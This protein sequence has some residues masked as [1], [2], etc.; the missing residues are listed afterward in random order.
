M[1]VVKKEAFT[2]PNEKVTIKYIKR[3][4]GMANDVDDN[5]VISG[6]LLN[7]AKIRYVAPLLRNGAIAN[8][9]S[10]EEKAYLEEVMGEGINL[11][12]FGKDSIWYD[13]SVSLGKDDA[14]NILDL[15]NPIDFLKFKILEGNK[16]EIAR[17]WVERDNSQ[18]YRFAI[19]REGE[20]RGETKKKLDIKK[21]AFKLYGKIED[22]KDKIISVL[23]LVSNKVPARSSSLEWLQGELEEQLDAKPGKF[24]DI[25]RDP[26][27]ET[28]ALINKAIEAKV[29]I[30]SGSLYKTEDGLDLCKPGEQPTYVRAIAYL[31]DDLNQDIRSMIQAKT[32]KKIK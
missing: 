30:R 9:L 1:G 31:N 25:L 10:I 29:I 26:D 15:S 21:L 32:D 14:G 7:D 18:R 28:K 24:V 6:G 3:R 12:V 11:G 22:D 2:L 20:L 16:G 8:L 13:L 5:H 17:S 23:K 4:K 27:F 19:V